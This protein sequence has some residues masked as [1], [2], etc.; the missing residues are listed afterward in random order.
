M[1]CV[2]SYNSLVILHPNRL[3]KMRKKFFLLTTMM[4]VYLMSGA[5]IR[6]VS[7]DAYSLMA[8]GQRVVP[9]MGEVHYS[10]IPTDEWET[11]IRKM[12]EGGITLV[13]SYVFWI[14]HEEQ[15][16]IFDWSGSRNLREFLR[17]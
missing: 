7:W 15:E 5:Q 16:G 9:A 2:K 1:N 11:E 10:R 8:D 14:H 13:A 3:S 17:V 6:D 12:K 4:T